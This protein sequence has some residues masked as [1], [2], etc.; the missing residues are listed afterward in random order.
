MSSRDKKSRTALQKLN[1]ALRNTPIAKMRLLCG[2]GYI[3]IVF[4]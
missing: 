4:I 3:S 2:R 1:D